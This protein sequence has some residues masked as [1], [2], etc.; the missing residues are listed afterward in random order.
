MKQSFN[1]RSD[2]NIKTNKNICESQ[3]DLIYNILN[4]QTYRPSWTIIKIYLVPTWNFIAF[5][6]LLE[7]VLSEL[8]RADKM[9]YTRQS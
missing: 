1:G 5:A 2:K 4:V 3:S 8:I 9:P 6:V 7:I